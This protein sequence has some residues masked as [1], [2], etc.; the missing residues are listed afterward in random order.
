MRDSMEGRMREVEP[1][2]RKRILASGD[3]NGPNVASKKTLLVGRRSDEMGRLQIVAKDPGAGIV[4]A[5]HG[6]ED[7]VDI[8]HNTQNKDWHLQ[9][10][11]RLRMQKM[12][13]L[14]KGGTQDY[15]K[16]QEEV[17]ESRTEVGSEAEAGLDG[18]NG[19]HKEEQRLSWEEEIAEN[20][21]A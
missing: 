15:S 9:A 18:G 6:E 7:D 19:S 16:G 1:L 20:K 3:M 2:L 5:G 12:K 10:G 11:T 8:N 13:S 4:A 17:Y 14:M 21:E